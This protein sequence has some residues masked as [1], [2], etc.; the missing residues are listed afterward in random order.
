MRAGSGPWS[1]SCSASKRWRAGNGPTRRRHAWKPMPRNVG[2][3]ALLDQAVA[4]FRFGHV[5]RATAAG[6]LAAAAVLAGARALHAGSTTA[7]SLAV[8]AFIVAAAATFVWL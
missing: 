5:L 1:S 6:A 4:R 2:L 3:S 7:S 8:A